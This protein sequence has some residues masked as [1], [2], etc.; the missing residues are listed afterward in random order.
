MWLFGPPNVSKLEQKR[1]VKGLIKLLGYKERAVRIKASEALGEL[2]DAR[3]VE[4]LIKALGDRNNETVRRTAAAALGKLG[5]GRAVVPLIKALGDADR[6]VC[7]TAAEALGKLGDARAVE[8]LIERLGISSWSVPKAAAALVK[9]GTALAV[10]PLIKALLDRL[11]V[12]DGVC[13][14][15][16]DG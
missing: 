7:V 6:G 10:E 9:L 13:L 15:W 3:A 14:F 2:G 16:N 1:N 8:P 4:P 11:R 5:D 12:W